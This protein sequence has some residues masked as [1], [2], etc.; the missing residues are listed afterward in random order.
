MKEQDLPFKVEEGTR[1][2][3]GRAKLIQLG[4]LFFVEGLIGLLIAVE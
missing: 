2:T 1:V 4:S 3:E